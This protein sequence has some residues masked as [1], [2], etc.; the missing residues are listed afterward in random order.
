M[1]KEEKLAIA[2]CGIITAAIGL[3]LAFG[4]FKDNGVEPNFA[5]VY[6][7]VIFLAILAAF[8]LIAFKVDL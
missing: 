8:G 2:F 5:A 6:A 3:W 1:G 4:Y 7:V